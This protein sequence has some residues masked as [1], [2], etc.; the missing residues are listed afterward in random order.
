MNEQRA[1]R[2][3]SMISGAGQLLLAVAGVCA[4]VATT[5]A[6]AN[7]P[8]R[9][10]MAAADE[11]VFKVVEEVRAALGRIESDLAVVKHQQSTLGDNLTDTAKR[12]REMETRLLY[13]KP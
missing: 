8:T 3:V 10:E 2:R 5:W 12:L 11:K 6:Q 9:T 7:F 13:Q 4:V 1:E